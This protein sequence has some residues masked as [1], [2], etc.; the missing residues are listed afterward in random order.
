M[1]VGERIYINPVIDMLRFACIMFATILLVHFSAIAQVSSFPYTE[2]FDTVTVPSLPVG[3]STSS[4]RLSSSDFVSSSSSPHTTPNCAYSSNSTIS[5][6]LISPAFNFTGRTPDKLQ[7]Y[8][9]RSSTHTSGLLVEASI[10]AGVTFPI[11]LGDTIK[12]P[13][14]T[15]YVLFSIP[16]PGSLAN[17][18]GVKIRWRIVGGTGGATATFRLDDVIV[19]TLVSYDLALGGVSLF[20]TLP[21]SQDSL[22]IKATLKNL[23]I[24]TATNY[25]VNFFCDLNNNSIPDVSEKFST[26]AGT[27]IPAS[28]SATIVAGHSPLKPGDYKF[29]AVVSLPL[30]ERTSNDTVAI[31][32]SVGYPRGSMLINEIMYAP[33]GDEPEWVELSNVATDTIN[34]KNWK[35]SDLTESTKNTLT[36]K[37]VFI[38]PLGY[39]IIAKDAAFVSMHPSLT[40]TVIIASFGALNNTTPDAVILYDSRSQPIDSVYYLPAWGGQ[41]G[42]SLERIDLDQSS[43]DGRNWGTSQDSSF[44]TPGR[45]N[46][47][48]RLANDLR[49]KRL[50]QS[51]SVTNTGI[52]PAINCVVENCGKKPVPGFAINLFLDADNDSRIDSLE[53]IARLNSMTPLSPMDSVI[54]TFTWQTPPA[55]ESHI[56]ADIEYAQ[57]ER[58]VNNR[59]TIPICV[60]Y[61]ARSLVV[62]EIMYDP[63]TGQNEWVEFY[64]RSTE[65]VDVRNWTL[66]DRPT[67]S[68][69]TNTTILTQTCLVPPSGMLVVA[70]DSTIVK[71]FPYLADPIA[72][73]RVLILNKPGGFGLS[74][75]GDD[76]VLRDVTGF[77]IDSISYSAEW[78]RPEVAD[79]KGRSLEK[80]NPDLDGNTKG[81]WTTCVMEAGGTPGRPNS[82]VTNQQTMTS[83]IAFSPNP[84]SPDGDGFEDFCII[85]YKMPFTSGFLHIRIFDRKGRLVRVLSNAMFS[86][87]GGEI[88]WDGRDDDK[89]RV[90]IGPY[91]VLIQATDTEGGEPVSAKG[92]V[93]VAT[94]L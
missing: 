35:I 4:N 73:A 18:N 55:G 9:A 23:G 42:R 76:V 64:N 87:G 62:N 31:L 71:L 38:P 15:S 65:P 92:V 40:S 52:V 45:E 74:A 77:T 11:A 39:C 32:V 26:V 63:L 69:S 25:V 1:I 44:S 24:Q 19:T 83:T 47:I 84:F 53:H 72:N 70:A 21:T 75:D 46:S 29:F 36:S 79:T 49:L 50:Y 6:S 28:D 85:Q 7:F 10:D 3:W 82:I 37:D 13:G 91:I 54:L 56:I 33:L 93:V 34:M 48:V 30:D 8:V 67:M 16:M 94:K 27:P 5:Q 57:D 51:R 20:P 88:V 43:T 89:Q 59:A 68:G 78:H 61:P 86:G 12:N 58:L 90:R 2:R 80:I 60:S 81:N 17:Q 14:T 66:C 41:G 22:V